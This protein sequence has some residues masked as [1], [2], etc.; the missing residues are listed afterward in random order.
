MST[1]P[2]KT[3]I[4]PIISDECGMFLKNK[5]S[6]IKAAAGAAYVTVLV[7]TAPQVSIR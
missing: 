5:K 6:V 4:I 3:T 7:L 1:I 2:E